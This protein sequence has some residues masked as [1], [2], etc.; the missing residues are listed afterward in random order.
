[1]AGTG[2]GMVKPMS[3]AGIK[4]IRIDTVAK[5]TDYSVDKMS[6]Q[7]FTLLSGHQT[8]TTCRK[9]LVIRNRLVPRSIVAHATP[10][11]PERENRKTYQSV[12]PPLS[13]TF[14]HPGQAPH[15]VYELV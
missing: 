10:A 5:D 8:S 2:V 14:D 12:W 15:A 3:K 11:G 7:T 6:S 9:S 4:K 13:Q 1:M